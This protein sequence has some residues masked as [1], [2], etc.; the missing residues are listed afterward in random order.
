MKLILNPH[1]TQIQDAPE[2]ALAIIQKALALP[3]IDGEETTSLLTGTT[4]PTRCYRRAIVAL[5]AAGHSPE[6]C[7]NYYGPKFDLAWWDSHSDLIKSWKLRG[8]YQPEGVRAL[9]L[10]M[11]GVLHAAVGSGKT[12]MAARCL[13]AICTEWRDGYWPTVLWLAQ[14]KE[15]VTQAQEAINSAGLARIPSIHVMCWQNAKSWS[16]LLPSVDVLIGDEIHASSDALF[17]IA[18]AC[19]NAWWR[20]GLTA[21]YVRGD[22]RELIMEAAFGERV[23]N[24]SQ[25]RV[26]EEGQLGGGEVRFVQVHQEGELADP[27]AKEAAPEIEKMLRKYRGWAR[28]E[29]KKTRTKAGKQMVAKAFKEK[30]NKQ[31]R[32]ITYRIARNVGVVQNS[33]RNALV[34]STANEYIAEGLSLLVLVATKEQG[35][36]LAELISGS[37]FVHSTMRVK[38]GR[39]ADVISD[40]QAGELRCMI[41]TSLADQGLD[42]PR[43]GAVFMAGGGEGGKEGDLVEQRS[44]RGQRTFAEKHI[45]LVVDVF[46]AGHPMLESQSWQRFNAYKRLGFKIE[47]PR[48]REMIAAVKRS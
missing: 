33:E 34:A 26:R 3:T 37:R 45:G 21:T 5:R 22:N 14:T 39:R 44:G 19:E 6:I 42:V 29:F 13:Q 24:I 43:I 9:L 10:R 48:L 36:E 31:R 11:G 17:N 8:K 32:Q 20:I 12:V 1:R 46:D 18:N 23:A 16:A 47:M 25:P 30:I 38:E 4:F 2:G 28:R 41:A 40:L 15:Q 35:R 7:Y 27:I